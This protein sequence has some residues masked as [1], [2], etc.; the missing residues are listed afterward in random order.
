MNVMAF[1]KRC[2]INNSDPKEGQLHEGDHIHDAFELHFSD[3]INVMIGENGTGKTTLLK[4]IYAATQ[5]SIEQTNAEKTNKFYNFFPP[6][7]MTATC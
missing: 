7:L 4:M 1:Q 6:T 3:G 5:W 2:R